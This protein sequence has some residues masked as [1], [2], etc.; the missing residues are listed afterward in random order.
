MVKTRFFKCVKEPVYEETSNQV[1][2]FVSYTFYSGTNRND[3]ITNNIYNRSSRVNF[4]LNNYYHTSDYSDE[5]VIDDYYVTHNLK[6]V[7]EYLEEVE[8]DIDEDVKRFIE[9]KEKKGDEIIIH[10][11]YDKY[12]TIFYTIYVT[13]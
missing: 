10:P 7:M 6:D 5:I 1:N 3:G 12:G 11:I 9:V 4:T 13:T 2:L 8:L